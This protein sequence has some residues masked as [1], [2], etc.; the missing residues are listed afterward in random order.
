MP[1]HKQEP[2]KTS[3]DVVQE[4]PHFE[5]LG[6]EIA[7]QEE[8]ESLKQA[9]ESSH[10]KS[11]E[12]LDG[13]QRSRAEFANYKKRV[14]REQ[15]QLYQTTAGV[16]IKRYLD[17]VDDLE[18][19]LNNRPQEGDGAVWAEGI[20]LIYRK[21]LSILENEGITPMDAQGKQ[22]DPNRHEAISSEDSNEYQ[23][24]QIIEVLK[25]GYVQGDRV[26]RPALVRVAR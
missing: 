24:G 5:N 26:L 9:L 6:E 8:I 15:A 19:A 11:E 25:Q 12:Y 1:K 20:D 17:I 21:F 14:E 2:Q 13:W 23:S 10:A 7:T 3:D 18:R 4:E 16:I 22:F